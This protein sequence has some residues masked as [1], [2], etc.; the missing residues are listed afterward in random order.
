MQTIDRMLEGTELIRKRFRATN[1]PL[2]K[3]SPPCFT[4]IEQNLNLQFLQDTGE[5]TLSFKLPYHTK[6]RALHLDRF[7]CISPSTLWA[8]S[9]TRIR[10]QNSTETIRV[11]DTSSRPRPLGYHSHHKYK[12]RTKE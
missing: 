10:T 6:V 4:F 5:E 8:F 3:Q 2:G 12:E 1:W 11:P 9:V 7:N